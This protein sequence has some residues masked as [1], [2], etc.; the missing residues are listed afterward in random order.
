[1]DLIVATSAPSL[2][3]AAGERASIRFLEFFA[4]AIRNPHTR[5]AYARAAGDFLAWCASAGVASITAVQPLHV[6]AW[7]ELQTQT[8]S[9]PTV[10]LRLA[11]IRHLFDWL[12]TGQIVPHNPAASVRGPSHTA[13]KGKTPVLDA[14][15]ARQLLDSIDVS[16]PIGLRDRALIALMVFSFARI[17]AALAMRVEDVYVQQRRLWVR[18]REKGGK[19]HAMPCHHTLEAYLH[20]YLD[21]TGLRDEPKGPLFRTITRG[22]GQL[23]KT[24]LPQANAYAMVRRRAVAAGIDTPIGNHTFRATGITTYLK[25]GGTLENAAV[26]ANHASTRTTQFYDRRC[27]DISL[28]EVERILL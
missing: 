12:V 22:T 26:M 14:S 4:S 8:L 11:A 6:A 9:A 23:S 16:T 20:D 19:Q 25:N 17:G 21:Q 15:E 5:R 18:L 13:K 24:P 7:I 27:D 3:L 2:V 1:M 10:K 28:D